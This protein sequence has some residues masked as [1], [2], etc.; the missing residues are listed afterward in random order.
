MGNL[1]EQ[2]N[3][4]KDLSDDQLTTEGSSPSGSVPPFLVMTEINRRKQMR[5]AYTAQQQ[6]RKPSTTVAEDLL[7]APLGTPARAAMGA[8]S[9]QGAG[10]IGIAAA[11]PQGGEPDVPAFAEGGLVSGD[12]MDRILQR[13]T[14]ALGSV[15]TDR[16]NLR[17][18]T[19]LSAGAA[20][21]SNGSSNFMKNLGAGIGA[22]GTAWDE[23]TKML[24]S[25]EDQALD[26]LM[27]IHEAD[28]AERLSA[29]DEQYRNRQED[30]LTTQHAAEL[31]KPTSDIQNYDYF[32]DL[33]PD[34]KADWVR[35]NGSGS[36]SD[37]T[38]RPRA[39][40]A[41]AGVQEDVRKEVMD[42]YEFDLMAAADPAEKARVQQRAEAEIKSKTD[43][44]FQGL[45]PDYVTL[46]PELTSGSGGGTSTSLG[47]DPAGLGL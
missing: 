38:L 19:L 23:G 40:A 14:A 21:M 31:G 12:I 6:R 41:Y 11:L 24:D 44:R 16:D 7:S 17:G 27:G 9:P 15:D 2:Q 47:P 20:M 36:G 22:G 45:Y 43:A 4:L 8:G 18:R 10:G 34:E 35:V 33:S 29:L 46:M 30:R 26:G 39:M 5:D 32:N 1:I 37:A 28:R 25:R 42:A 13:R 3:R